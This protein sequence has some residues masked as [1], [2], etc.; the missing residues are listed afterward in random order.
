ML[1]DHPF[2]LHGSKPAT[3]PCAWLNCLCWLYSAVLQ[4][5]G[6][7]DVIPGDLIFV[8]REAAVSSEMGH[9]ARLG[10][11]LVVELELTLSEALLGFERP[12]AHLDGTT[13]RVSNTYLPS[14]AAAS[15]DNLHQQKQDRGSTVIRPGEFRKVTGKGMPKRGLPGQFG[16]LYI[17]FAVAF[18]SEVRRVVTSSTTRNYSKMQ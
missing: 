9:F 14:A 16:D 4:D 7:P 18:P 1:Y 13:L 2:A 8:L 11:H 3:P 12:L 17:R 5:P 15:K 6:I 10:D